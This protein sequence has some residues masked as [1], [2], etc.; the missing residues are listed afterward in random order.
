MERCL[1]SRYDITFGI[2]H[3]ASSLPD[4]WRDESP[5]IDRR[6]VIVR[7][8]FAGSVHTHHLD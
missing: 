1:T 8:V 7:K 5:L 2:Q 3:V 4:G 6:Y